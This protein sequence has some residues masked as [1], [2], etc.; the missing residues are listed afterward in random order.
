[1]DCGSIARCRRRIGYHL[2][3]PRRKAIIES[4][5]SLP[6]LLFFAFILLALRSPLFRERFVRVFGVTS[7]APEPIIKQTESALIPFEARIP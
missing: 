4:A 6:Y 5:I 3:V 2:P 7:L 1:M